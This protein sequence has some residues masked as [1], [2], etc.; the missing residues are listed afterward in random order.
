VLRWWCDAA[1]LLDVGLDGQ[2]TPRRQI[3][4]RQRLDPHRYLP[5]PVL[6]HAPH[7]EQR[8]APRQQAMLLVDIGHQHEVE[9]PELVFE[10]QEDDALG[11][12]RALSGDRQARDGNGCA[13]RQQRKL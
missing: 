1:Q 2:C 8:L 7:E 13:V 12:G 5:F 11:A 4:R 6:E 3:K 10:E 9:Q